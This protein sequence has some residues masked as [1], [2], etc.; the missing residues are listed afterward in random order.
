[1]LRSRG[2]HYASRR[3]GVPL[4]D[5][6]GSRRQ[7]SLVEHVRRYAVRQLAHRRG[8][9]HGPNPPQTS[10]SRT[11]DRCR[12]VEKVNLV[13][14]GISN[15][16]AHPNI[17]PKAAAS[18]P[19]GFVSRPSG[20]PSS[21]AADF[22]SGDIRLIQTCDERPPRNVGYLSSPRSRGPL[23]PSRRTTSVGTSHAWRREPWRL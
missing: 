16:W 22:N 2:W 15:S 3:R 23:P 6:A 14:L 12:A 20:R 19:P 21:T 4:P 17:V 8:F 13:A 11:G 18:G 9:N 5:G 10:T 7:P 1:M